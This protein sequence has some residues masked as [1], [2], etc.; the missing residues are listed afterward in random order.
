VLCT[1][2][3]M[4]EPS[5]AGCRAQAMRALAATALVLGLHIFVAPAFA[6]E[7]IVDDADPAVQLSGAWQTS[8]TTPGFYGGGYLFHMPGH[9][10]AAVRWPFPASAIAGQYR[11]YA[12]W[13]SGGN[14]AKTAPYQVDSRDGIHELQIN[15]TTGGGQWHLL[16]TY[17]F[18]PGANEGVTLSG[19]AD[20][21]VVADAIAW[22]GPLGSDSASE[23]ADPA[24]A[25]TVQHAVDSGDQPWRLDPL[26]VARADTAA[27]GL[28]PD[29]PLQLIGEESGSARVRAQHA[30]RTYEIRLIQPA[31]LG[32]SGI[33]V[34]TS[35]QLTGPAAAP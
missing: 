11:A 6:D 1:P 22:V 30:G 34:V 31:R 7:L 23:L 26:Q 24:S 19:E 20:G 35:V 10:A 15:Q 13:S 18:E 16:G 33:W 12:R 32:L 5:R 17:A 21:V 14:R 27:F 28:G 9:G 8:A 2:A 3:G 29:D 25:Q 4:P